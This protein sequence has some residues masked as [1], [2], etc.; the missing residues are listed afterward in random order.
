MNNDRPGPSQHSIDIA[1]DALD[2]G[3]RAGWAKYY[4]LERELT[5]V[6][7]EL[8]RVLQKAEDSE[9]T[10]QYAAAVLRV[11]AP[12]LVP[13][14]NGGDPGVSTFGWGNGPARYY[15]TDN[16]TGPADYYDACPTDDV[17]DLRAAGKRDAA[18]WLNLGD[19]VRRRQ[20]WRA[21]QMLAWYDDQDA[22]IPHCSN[23]ELANCASWDH[24]GSEG[25]CTKCG[26]HEY[27]QPARTER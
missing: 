14:L 7:S 5:Q 20:D 23:C 16:Q 9:R 21:E 12:S 3:R 2:K 22:S 24:L 27:E 18:S 10:S 1:I 15:G 19:E 26:C 8:A 6:R 25:E 13:W 4:A 11:I 17:D